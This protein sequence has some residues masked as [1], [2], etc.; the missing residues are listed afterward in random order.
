M[1]CVQTDLQ[2]LDQ[3]EADVKTL[4]ELATSFKGLIEVLDTNTQS[5]EKNID[6]FTDKIKVSLD[7]GQ[8]EIMA[9]INTIDTQIDDN[10][11][12]YTDKKTE[13]AK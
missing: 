1:G 11:K 13:K 2:K 7:S 12:A 4:K 5:L 3:M 8:A 6:E 10:I 9:K